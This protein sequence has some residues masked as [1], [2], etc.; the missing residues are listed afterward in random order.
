[1][2]RSS[3]GR[4]IG[5]SDASNTMKRRQFLKGTAVA[6]AASTSAL[7]TPA[8]AQSRI[9]WKM[10]TAWPKN[11]PGQGT[12]AVRFANSVEAAT[13]GRLK[14]HV[15]SAGEIVP[16]FESFDAVTRGAADLMH[17]SPYYWPNKSKALMFYS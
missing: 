14:I 1:R 5:M 8:I 7:A 15:Y 4:E 11:F 3:P 17:A 9:E 12:G 6:G 2:V 10:V 13:E 16:A